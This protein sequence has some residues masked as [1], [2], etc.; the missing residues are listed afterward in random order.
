[1]QSTDHLESFF[2]QDIRL[3]RTVLVSLLVALS[4]N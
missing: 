4:A 2:Q 1:M 3:T